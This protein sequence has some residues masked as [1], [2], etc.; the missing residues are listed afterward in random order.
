MS[1]LAVL[2]RATVGKKALVAVTGFVL[3]GF[4]LGHMA[5]NL[6]AFVPDPQPG[7]A[8]IDVYA[9]YL[10]EIGVPLLPHGWFLWLTR[11]ALLSA[12][13]VHVVCVLQLAAR[14]RAARPVGY[15]VTTQVEATRSARA[16]LLTGSLLPGNTATILFELAIPADN[17]DANYAIRQT[18]LQPASAPLGLPGLLGLGLGALIALW[19]RQAQ[20]ARRFAGVIG[21]HRI[22]HDW[23][24]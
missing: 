13:V 17:P 21:Q 14:N 18:A 4:L 11:A 9:A 2:Y 20:A 6:K 3:L 1:R 22:R 16:M 19:C 12:L 8:D 24:A 23:R 15:R 10:R 7:V 5:G